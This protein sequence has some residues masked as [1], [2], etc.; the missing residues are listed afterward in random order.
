M[1]GVLSFRVEVSRADTSTDWDCH[2]WNRR[3]RVVDLLDSEVTDWV[4]TCSWEPIGEFGSKDEKNNRTSWSTIRTEIGD[5]ERTYCIPIIGRSSVRQ[6]TNTGMMRSSMQLDGVKLN[7]QVWHN[8]DVCRDVKSVR[9][10]VFKGS[11][12][13]STMIDWWDFHYVVLV[14]NL[15]ETIYR[16]IVLAWLFNPKLNQSVWGSCN[17]RR[18]CQWLGFAAAWKSAPWCCL[19]SSGAKIAPELIDDSLILPVSTPKIVAEV[20]TATCGV[21]N[22][23]WT[24]VQCTDFPQQ[25]QKKKFR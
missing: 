7:A 5:K 23:S 12:I 20:S 15:I 21:S 11:T 16:E 14:Q 18:R 10:F 8:R 3:L 22:D 1:T 4:S 24:V 13:N 25:R 19:S 6:W 2:G 9:R 17:T